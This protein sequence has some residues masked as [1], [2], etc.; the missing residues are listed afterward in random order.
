MNPT[1][2]LSNKKCGICYENFINNSWDELNDLYE[3]TMEEDKHTID[4]MLGLCYDDRFECL[5]CKNTIC[6]ICITKMPDPDDEECDNYDGSQDT[7]EM[8]GRITCPYC[9]TKDFR[10]KILGH[11]NNKGC[12]GILPINLIYDLKKIIL[13]K[14]NCSL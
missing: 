7:M 2:T 4:T 10:L 5:I 14:V 1:I 3:K 12:G 6:Y 9:K 8:T 13:I 11:L